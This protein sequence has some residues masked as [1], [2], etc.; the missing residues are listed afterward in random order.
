MYMYM[1]VYECMCVSEHASKI[2]N[3]ISHM[4]TC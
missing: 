1:S 3:K 2:S 4:H